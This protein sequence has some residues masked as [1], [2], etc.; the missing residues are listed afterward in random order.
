MTKCPNCGSPETQTLLDRDQCLVCGQQFNAAGK[1]SGGIDESTRADYL[2]R[3]APRE[4]NVVGNI[5]DLQRGGA[6]A[7]SGDEVSVSGKASKK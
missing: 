5:A 4:T 3:L 1:V 7:A 2:R 6:A